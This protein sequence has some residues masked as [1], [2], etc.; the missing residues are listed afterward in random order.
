MENNYQTIQNVSS[1]V[2]YEE[3][4]HPKN[5]ERPMSYENLFKKYAAGSENK[6]DIE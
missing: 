1:I 3:V 4:A 2:S 5:E 6:I